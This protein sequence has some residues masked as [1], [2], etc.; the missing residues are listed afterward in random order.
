[1]L[2]TEIT[3]LLRNLKNL[4]TRAD[5]YSMRRSETFLRLRELLDNPATTAKDLA[6]VIDEDRH[7][8]EVLINL[9][10][11][12]GFSPEECKLEFAVLYLGFDV[13]KDIVGVPS[14]L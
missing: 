12:I 14:N 7:F 1:V 4:E 11:S 8:A 5:K 9:L 13:L 6:E 3:S 10:K 2:Y